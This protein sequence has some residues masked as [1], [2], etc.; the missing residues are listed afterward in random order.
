MT[1]HIKI[2]KQYQG[3]ILGLKY[4]SVLLSVSTLNIAEFI[5]TQLDPG[6][7]QLLSISTAN[8]LR[9]CNFQEVHSINRALIWLQKLL[10][11]SRIPIFDRG[12]VLGGK[13][14]PQKI[15]CNII[16]P[17]YDSQAHGLINLLI[18]FLNK[19]NS[20]KLNNSLKVVEEILNELKNDVYPK[21]LLEQGINS[22]HFAHAA[23]QTNIPFCSYPLAHK[24]GPFWQF[25]L[26]NQQ[27]IFQSSLCDSESYLSVIS[28]CDKSLCSA[29]LRQAGFPAPT[30]C[31]VYSLQ[32]AEQAFQIIGTPCVVKP[33][34]SER[35]L[36]VSKDINTL[37]TLRE[38]YNLAN[39]YS[40][41]IL[42]E[43]QVEGTCHRLLVINH[44]LVLAFKRSL[45][46]LK[47]NGHQTISE[48]I[49]QENRHPFRCQIRPIL[50]TF[51]ID[52]F[53]INILQAQGLSLDSVLAPEQTITI[54]PPGGSSIPELVLEQVHPDNIKLAEDVT[55]L[56]NLKIAGIDFITTDI[57]QPWH[58]NDSIINE[59]NSCPQ[60]TM[61]FGREIYSTILRQFV[62][63]DGRIPTYAFIGHKL[64]KQSAIQWVDQLQK[65]QPHCAFISADNVSIPQRFFRNLP[66]K[67]IDRVALVLADKSVGSLVVHLTPEE[68]INAGLPLDRLTEMRLFASEFKASSNLSISSAQS[69]FATACESLIIL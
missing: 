16:F 2:L 5:C 68:L 19:I 12:K 45:Q 57:S 52:D 9:S 47:G 58:E 10:E 56:I 42:V 11:W 66:K 38:A 3:F 36:G 65:S 39:Q 1:A 27:V 17:V 35:G 61:H 37:D 43:K 34:D 44:K 62:K 8:E 55:K 7:D 63:G 14:N 51:K 67:M 21:L 48:L 18:W 50:D 54:H 4:P 28:A 69:T 59:V 31:L 6:I 13:V 22:I 30:H 64:A 29:I 26:G 53:L 15:D 20:L 46:Y 40:R 23:Y 33:S 49:E 32:Q 41:Q 60:I 24:I 25:G